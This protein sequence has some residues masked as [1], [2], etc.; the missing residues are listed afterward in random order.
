[1]S[2][3]SGNSRESPPA[4]PGLFVV[5]GMQLAIPAGGFSISVDGEGK[6]IGELKTVHLRID[7]CA[8]W[9]AIAYQHL[10]VSESANEELLR[11]VQVNNEEALGM[12]LERAADAGMQAISAACA[13]IDAY[14][15]LLREHTQIDKSTRDSW[16]KNRTARHIQ[17]AEVIS[18][19]F[20]IPQPEVDKM[21]AILKQAFPIR[22]KAL[23]PSAKMTAPM[24]YDEIGRSTARWLV[25]V[26]HEN[27][28]MVVG[29]CLMVIIGT[30]AR[31]LRN[32]VKEFRDTLDWTAQ[33]VAPLV[34]EWEKHYDRLGVRAA[35]PARQSG[36]P[37]AV[38]GG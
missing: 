11:A 6:F 29:Q 25:M 34:I 32:H 31:D 3:D 27:A 28:R 21:R 17:I 9:M 1:L 8:R 23:H 38:G 4:P 2:E 33:L 22:D 36:T 16:T 12:A 19:T 20:K 30:I 24:N 7:M 37:P 14:Y 5:R 18:R 13:A 10:L 35:P 15:A 26:R